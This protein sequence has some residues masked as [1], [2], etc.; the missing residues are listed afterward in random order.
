M[1]RSTDRILTTHT[2]SLPRPEDLVELLYASESGQAP[3]PASLDRRVAEAVVASV[4]Q[5]VEAGVDVVNDGEMGKISYSTYVTGRLSGYE[6]QVH[7]PRRPRPDAIDFPEWDEQTRPARAS[8][9][10]QRLACTGPIRYIG[11]QAVQRDVA[12]L[13]AALRGAKV[14][15]AFMTAASPG[16]ISVFQP[17]QYYASDEQYLLALAEAMRQ[18]YEAI[19]QAGFLLQLDCPDLTGLSAVEK[20][21]QPPPDLPLRVEAL[22]HAVANIPADRMRLHLCWGNYEGPHHTDV[23]LKD[24]IGEVLEA[25]PMGLSFEGANPRHEHEWNVFEQVQLPEG[26][27]IIPGVLDSTTNYIEHPELVAQRLARYAGLVG[28]E[29]VIAG[30]DCGFGTFAGTPSVHPKI[31]LAKLQTMAEG[32][33]LASSQLWP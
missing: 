14:R 12:N 4:R 7:V 19:H 11:Q 27:V 23:P 25:K 30:S 9:R 22:N 2:G 3:D 5:Q 29:N 10:V 31:V 13:K 28:R 8:F 18:E 15:E 24:I 33:R 17:N 6:G 1:E 20:P 32:A 26:K 21:G 16:V